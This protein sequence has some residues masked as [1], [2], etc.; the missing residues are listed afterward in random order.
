MTDRV[1]VGLDPLLPQ[2]RWIR[3]EGAKKSTTVTKAKSYLWRRRSCHGRPCR[4]TIRTGPQPLTICSW[5]YVPVCVVCVCVFVCVR[6]RA[7]VCASVNV[8]VCVCVCML[9]CVCLCVCLSCESLS[10][11]HLLRYVHKQYVDVFLI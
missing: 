6:A 5:R 10:G 11:I 7:H 1:L 4:S 2:E 9:V 3:R 8:C